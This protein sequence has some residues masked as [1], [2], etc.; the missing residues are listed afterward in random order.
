MPRTTHT[1]FHLVKVDGVLV[2]S[3]VN[4]VIISEAIINEI[5]AELYDL[6]D[7][8]G[9]KKLLLN[10]GNVEHCSTMV[11]G[12]LV[13]LLKRVKSNEGQLKLCCIHPGFLEAFKLTKLDRIFEI[14]TEE[15][16]ALDA[17]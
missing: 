6:A 8:G 14:Y 4:K 10:F 9:H 15:Q 13:N 11:H 16:A 12:K 1:H 2:V 5:G 17:F 7:D 3:F